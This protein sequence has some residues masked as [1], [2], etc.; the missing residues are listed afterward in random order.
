[1][2]PQ[3]QPIPDQRL[4]ELTAALASA[5]PAPGGG[6]AAAVAAS[7]GASLIAMVSRLS[8]GRPRHAD[9]EALHREAIAAADAA[10][11]ELLGRAEADAAAYAAYR[12]A[13]ELPSD[14][15]SERMTRESASREAAR[16]ATEVPL[17]T[18]RICDA[19]V[20]LVLRCVGRTNVHASGDLEV[21]ALLLE[22]AARAAAVNV[23]ANLPAIGDDGYASA[24]SAEVSQRLQHIQVTVDRVRE[25]IARG[26]PGQPAASG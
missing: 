16:A 19:Q 14:T 21:A 24:V 23:R 9:H 5:R 2:D 4:E 12:A 13:R 15:D 7:L 1:M 8:L 18:L 10:R 6:A 3:A 17:E 11:H 26:V 20:E 22:S 25:G